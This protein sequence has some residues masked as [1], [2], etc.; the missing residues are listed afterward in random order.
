MAS[1]ANIRGKNISPSG[2]EVGQTVR[3]SFGPGGKQHL[4]FGF[5]L[6]PALW[7]IHNHVQRQTSINQSMNVVSVADARGVFATVLLLMLYYL[8]IQHENL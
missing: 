5:A 7:M 8:F 1:S 3:T 2:Y 4:F 6:T